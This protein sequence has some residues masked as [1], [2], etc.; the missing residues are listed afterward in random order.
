M[1]GVYDH[2]EHQLLKLRFATWE[3]ALNKANSLSSM[4]PPVVIEESWGRKPEDYH[5]K[6]IQRYSVLTLPAEET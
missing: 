3:E 4:Q 1:Y 5:R 2:K 6:V